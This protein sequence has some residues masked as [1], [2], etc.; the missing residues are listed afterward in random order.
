[1]NPCCRRDTDGDGHCPVHPHGQVT[2]EL[3]RT[4]QRGTWVLPITADE[5]SATI[6]A[7]QAA[8]QLRTSDHRSTARPPWPKHGERAWKLIVSL[9]GGPQWIERLG[10]HRIQ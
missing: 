7:H 9:E 8:D 10:G 6:C 3:R 1:M 5:L 2:F 4:D